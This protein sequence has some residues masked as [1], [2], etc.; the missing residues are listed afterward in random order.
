MKPIRL[1]YM[2]LLL[3]VAGFGCQSKESDSES[4]RIK[5]SKVRDEELGRTLLHL[6]PNGKMT[7]RLI[8]RGVDVNAKDS[9]GMTPLHT[10][11]IANH[12]DIVE[13]IVALRSDINTK[14]HR[15]Q[16]PLFWAVTKSRKDMA[17]WLIAKAPT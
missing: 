3:M 8:I 11:V 2:A 6:A 5:P 9:F 14:S 15:S 1:V 16:T 4:I 7:K 13:V 12:R 17:E 10:A